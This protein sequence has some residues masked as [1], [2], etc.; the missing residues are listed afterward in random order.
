MT[1][2]VPTAKRSARLKQ[3]GKIDAIKDRT[4]RRKTRQRMEAERIRL[5]LCFRCGK[6]VSGKLKHCSE[7]L[8]KFREYEGRKRRR[9]KTAL[10]RFNLCRYCKVHAA[11]PKRRACKIC[12][13]KHR[14][15]GLRLRAKR[16]SE[17]LCPECGEPAETGICCDAC[18]AK[19]R[20][21]WHKR[22]RNEQT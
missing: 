10:I 1:I 14:Q 4:R 5:G 21:Q 2:P 9:Q 12:H 6:P 7:C 11:L 15:C 22:R 3:G 16:R 13:E 19:A 20:A 17:G 18:K 8:E